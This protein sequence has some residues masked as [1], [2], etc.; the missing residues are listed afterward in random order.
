VFETLSCVLASRVAAVH[1]CQLLATACQKNTVAA[2]LHIAETTPSHHT[3]SHAL[4][5][6]LLQS[7]LFAYVLHHSLVAGVL[8]CII[9]Q[10][11]NG[12]EP[13]RVRSALLCEWPVQGWGWQLVC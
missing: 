5:H 4:C 3:P 2:S 12:P 6:C 1:G 13:A 11:V 8:L 9:W 7:A 10:H